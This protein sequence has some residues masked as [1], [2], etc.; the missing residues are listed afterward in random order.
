MATNDQLLRALS[1][2]KGIKATLPDHY[3]VEAH[4]ANE[5]NSA[6]QKMEKALGIGLEEYK[7]PTHQIKP[8]P[9]FLDQES[10][11]PIYS[12]ELFCDHAILLQKVDSVLEYASN[13]LESRSDETK[14]C[15]KRDKSQRKVFI[16][17][18][19]NNEVKDGVARLIEKLK[20]EAIILHEQPS[21]GKTIIEKFFEYSDVGF[22]IVCLTADDVGA[23]KRESNPKLT[24]RARQNVILELGFFLGRIG[25]EKVF[26]LYENGVEIPSDYYGVIFE[27]IDN[28][29]N[30]K[31]PLARELRE[32][33][34]EIDTTAIL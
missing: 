4:W 30:W 20:L 9:A 27:P 11:G 3:V 7:I 16:V 31:L 18:G 1:T 21:K 24:P 15:L 17:H 22:A 33:G 6:I 25:R 28:K 2:I 34:F 29:G 10:G 23:S 19:H 5:F 12:K 14:E 13:Y 8:E 26:V 32:A